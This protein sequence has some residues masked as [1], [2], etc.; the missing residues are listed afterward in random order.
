MNG[1]APSPGAT[2]KGGIYGP[3]DGYIAAA[4]THHANL[5]VVGLT[6]I[7]AGAALLVL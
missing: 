7:V 5:A 4:L 6:G 3:D 2:G 1:G